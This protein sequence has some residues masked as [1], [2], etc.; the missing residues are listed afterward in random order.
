MMQSK[1]ND[2][3]D[4]TENNKSSV[5]ADALAEDFCYVEVK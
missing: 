1:Q 2:S 4:R 5:R 3:V